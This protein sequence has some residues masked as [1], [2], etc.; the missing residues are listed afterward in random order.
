MIVSL[1]WL[2]FWLRADAPPRVVLGNIEQIQNL[3]IPFYFNYDYFLLGTST[4]LT[5]ITLA[6][7]HGRS[8][9]K[10]SYIKMSEVWFVVCCLFIFGSLIEFAFV[11]AIFR[12]V[13]NFELKKVWISILHSIA[14]D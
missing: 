13:E 2:S 14:V 3:K 6:S 11:N 5:F 8:L 12:R 1:S 4:M 10:V 9:P 7:S